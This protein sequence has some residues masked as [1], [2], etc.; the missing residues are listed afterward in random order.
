MSTFFRWKRAVGSSL[1]K[2]SPDKFHPTQAP[3]THLA[4]RLPNFPPLLFPWTKS[5]SKSV[6]SKPRLCF[7]YFPA[8]APSVPRFVTHTWAHV[9]MCCF[10]CSIYF[11]FLLHSGQNKA[12][13]LG[14]VDH[15]SRSFPSHPGKQEEILPPP[16]LYTNLVRGKCH[17][18]L[19]KE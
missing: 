4:L 16:P 10:Y 11:H 18:L 17:C 14:S 6:L 2:Y 19:L 7:C 8:C 12:L 1:L 3:A 9:N 15:K 13:P 5:T